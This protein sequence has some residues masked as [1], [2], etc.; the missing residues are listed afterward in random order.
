MLYVV[1]FMLFVMAALLLSIFGPGIRSWLIRSAPGFDEVY[2]FLFR[3]CGEIGSCPVAVHEAVN[4][5]MPA[6]KC[7]DLQPNAEWV[8]DK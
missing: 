5:D 8:L 4:V 3:Y 6:G 7:K 1:F 2:R